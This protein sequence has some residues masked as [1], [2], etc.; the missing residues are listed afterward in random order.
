MARVQHWGFQTWIRHRLL[1]LTLLECSQAALIAKVSN[2]LTERWMTNTYVFFLPQF[3]LFLLPRKDGRLGEYNNNSGRPLWSVPI[4]FVLPN[5]GLNWTLFHTLSGQSALYGICPMTCLVALKAFDRFG[6][7]VAVGI[8][9]AYGRL[10]NWRSTYSDSF[11]LVV[12][13]EVTRKPS[14]S[15]SEFWAACL[16]AKDP[17]KPSQITL[18]TSSLSSR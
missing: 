8:L 2:Y 18:E 13:Y 10:L 17:V 15:P 3:F 1:E 14:K 9:F 4:S 5:S 6:S 12:R 16:Y 7:W 11:P